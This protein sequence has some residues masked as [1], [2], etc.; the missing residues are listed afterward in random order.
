[1]N[2]DKITLIEIFYRTLKHYL[3]RN[4]LKILS[5][6]R[7]AGQR[8]V[9]I[10]AL[11]LYRYY[12]PLPNEPKMFAEILEKLHKDTELSMYL[13]NSGIR[14]KVTSSKY[15]YEVV[16]SLETLRNLIDELRNDERGSND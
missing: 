14:I 1:M 2:K 11:G 5:L 16:L 8:Y 13:G 9:R 6:A 12:K 15:K 7:L 3:A 10:S 4:G